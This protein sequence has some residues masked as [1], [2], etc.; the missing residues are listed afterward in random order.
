MSGHR[1]L[2]HPPVACADREN[3]DRAVALA[4]IL[5]A[6]S[7]SRL[8]A[9]DHAFH[10]RTRESNGGVGYPLSETLAGLGNAFSPI[11]HHITERYRNTNAMSTENSHF[12]MEMFGPADP[13]STEQIEGEKVQNSR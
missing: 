9:A 10:E 12:Q 2:A 5:F 4:R 1:D 6:T 8:V 7:A 13:Q 3:P 11:F